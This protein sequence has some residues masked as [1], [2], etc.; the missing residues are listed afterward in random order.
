MDFLFHLLFAYLQNVKTWFG[1]CQKNYRN[2][3]RIVEVKKCT[4]QCKYFSRSLDKG[5]NTFFPSFH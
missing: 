5:S 1:I 2:I 3:F 4:M